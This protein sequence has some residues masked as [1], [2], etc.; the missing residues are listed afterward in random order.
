M[1]AL[2]LEIQCFCRHN[3]LHGLENSLLTKSKTLKE[4]SHY[5]FSQQILKV[6]TMQ[7]LIQRTR[8]RSFTTRL[9]EHQFNYVKSQEKPSDY[10]RNL[11]EKD[12]QVVSNE[13]P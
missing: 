13:Q 3:V 6:H 12:Y 9:S 2:M 7:K 1:N 5:C 10:I 8:T 4:S 11:I